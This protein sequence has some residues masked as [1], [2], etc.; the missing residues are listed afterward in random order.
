MNPISR[1]GIDRITLT[2]AGIPN[3]EVT[4][5]YRS[6]FVYSV[7]YYSLIKEIVQKAKDI[8]LGSEG[9]TSMG[10]TTRHMTKFSIITAI[11]KVF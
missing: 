10:R 3:D 9:T 1:Y 11:W 5:L 8:Y 7:G 2:N 6:L 4:H